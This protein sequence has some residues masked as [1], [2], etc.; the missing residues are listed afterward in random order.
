[1]SSLTKEI[2]AAALPVPDLRYL[3]SEQARGTACVWGGEPLDDSAIE[4]GWRGV[5]H[6][7]VLGRWEPRAC[8]SCVADAAR[9]ALADHVRECWWCDGQDCDTRHALRRLAEVCP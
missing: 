6:M 5:G 7:G 9:R 8:T 2:Q 3:Q 1:M 4:L